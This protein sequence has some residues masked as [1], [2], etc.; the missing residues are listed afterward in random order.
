MAPQNVS[1]LL[2]T[3]QHDPENADA[4]AAL[5]ALAENGSSVD[6]DAVALLDQARAVH[7]QRAEYRA[8]A[9][10]LEVLSRL[11]QHDPDRAAAMLKE[12]GRVYREELLDDARAI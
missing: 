5:A 9:Q 2:G 3:L 11:T 1:H 4:L 8:V 10:L 12:L 7:D 6:S